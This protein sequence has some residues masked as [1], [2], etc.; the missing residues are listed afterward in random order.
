MKPRIY[1]D[2]SVLSALFDTRKPERRVLTQE[3]WEK[4]D[5][6]ELGSSEIC[7]N[8]LN[9]IKEPELRTLLL[10]LLSDMNLLAVNDEIWALAGK[11]IRGQA[12]SSAM[13]NDA[14][15]VA[16]AVYHRYDVVASWNFR[17]L[18]NRRRRASVLAINAAN[19]YP[20]IEIVA[21]PEI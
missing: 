4:R 8:E 13:M 21:P 11:Y 2:T 12:F 19:G 10:G 14:L 7:Q 18:V 5:Q 17:H 15:H 6:F 3:F 16:T 20:S 9:Q 1:L